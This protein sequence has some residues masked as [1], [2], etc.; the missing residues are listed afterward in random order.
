MADDYSPFVT[1]ERQGPPYET[2]A[3]F[4]M[5]ASAKGVV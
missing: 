2:K 4:P 5:S 3:Y 1:G